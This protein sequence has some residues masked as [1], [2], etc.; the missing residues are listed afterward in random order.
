MITFVVALL[1]LIAG[2]LLYGKYVDR[3]FGSRADIQTPAYAKADGVDYLPL[4]TWKVYLIQFLNIAGTGPIF[5]AILGIMYG[6]AAYMWIVLGCIFGGAVHD[7]LTGMISI[8]NGGASIPELVGN[9]LGN[10]MRVFMRVLSLVLLILVGTVFARTPADLIAGLTPTDGFWGGGL[11]WLIVIVIYYI[12]ATLLPIDKL[13]GRLYPLFGAALLLMAVGIIFGLFTEE[14]KMPEITDAFHNHYPKGESPLFPCLFITIACGAI[15]GFHATQSPLMARCLQK[16]TKGRLVFYG[17]MI[18]EGIVA[19]IWAAGAIKFADSLGVPGDTPYE[20]LAYAMTE[21][22]A[23]SMNPSVIV[24]QVC[25]SWLGT[26]GSVLAILGVVAAPITSGDTAFRS[27][28][29]IASD[30]MKMKQ[31]KVVK[32][33]VLAIPLFALAIMLFFVDFQVI[34]RYFAWTNQSLATVALWAFTVWLVKKEKNYFITLIPA[35]FMT[36]VCSSYIMVAPEG[37]Q[38]DAQIAYVIAGV[39]T[40]IC[41]VLFCRWFKRKLTN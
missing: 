36:F 25:T 23:H 8:R 10:G 21:G 19:L 30:F 29:L 6:P 34:W 17:A 32:R 3:V 4:P 18:T 27:A 15:S 14:G 33:L 11:F 39:V 41:L 12:L 28:R 24:H 7:Y 35:L 5:G 16:E 2:Y 9:E 1:L 38:M 22:G 13:I 40:I 26:V 20:K 37:F 31:D